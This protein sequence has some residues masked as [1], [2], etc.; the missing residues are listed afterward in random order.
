MEIDTE[1]IC[2][3]D[4]TNAQRCFRIAVDRTEMP[5]CQ[6]TETMPTTDE[7]W[8]A[9]LVNQLDCTIECAP[10]IKEW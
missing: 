1:I 7:E 6:N 8:Y 3:Y 4:E 9:E 2:I 10:I 5:V